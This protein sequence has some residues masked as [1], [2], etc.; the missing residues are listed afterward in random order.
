MWL[1]F[2]KY[3]LCKWRWKR[4]NEEITDDDVDNFI[5]EEIVFLCIFKFRLFCTKN[6]NKFLCIFNFIYFLMVQLAYVFKSL[7]KKHA[8]GLCIKSLYKKQKV[9]NWSYGQ[10][11]KKKGKIW[12]LKLPFF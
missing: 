12:A 8:V 3:F 1:F 2:G 11:T 10:K 5:N 4:F 9:P 6:I 7:Y